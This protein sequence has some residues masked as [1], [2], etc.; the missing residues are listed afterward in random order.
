MKK[1]NN[2]INKM[3]TLEKS[4]IFSQNTK[5]ENN[6][7][8]EIRNYFLKDKPKTPGVLI[9]KEELGELRSIAK[10][11]GPDLP[12]VLNDSGLIHKDARYCNESM[13]LLM[14]LSQAF[15][16]TYPEHA[17][18]YWG[19]FANENFNIELVIMIHQAIGSELVKIL[20][21]NSGIPQL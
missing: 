6:G 9:T 20:S 4:K 7:S 19:V 17:V 2:V 14:V 3:S 11:Y 21:P 18:K 1:I 15:V 5:Y 8:E 16:G 10:N 12:K 13:A